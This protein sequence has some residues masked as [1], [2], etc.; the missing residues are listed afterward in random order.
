MQSTKK[1][2]WI[3]LFFGLI[4][5]GCFSFKKS[6]SAEYLA[7]RLVHLLITESL[8]LGKPKEPLR[9]ETI[10]LGKWIRDELITNAGQSF[11]MDHDTD[12]IESSRTQN[13][14]PI[15]RALIQQLQNINNFLFMNRAVPKSE[16]A[17]ERI[18]KAVLS[19]ASI[20][21]IRTIVMMSMK[22]TQS[23][24][25]GLASIDP[26]G[27]HIHFLLVPSETDD[28]LASME[29][30]DDPAEAV[31]TLRDLHAR[32]PFLTI[33]AERTIDFLESDHPEEQKR[34]YYHE[35]L[36]LF[37]FYAAYSY[38]LGQERQFVYI[39]QH[40]LPGYFIGVF[41]IHPSGNP[42]SVED[43]LGS[44]LQK[45][46]VIEPKEDGF[47]VH[48][49]F[50]GHNLNEESRVIRYRNDSWNLTSSADPVH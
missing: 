48:Y 12:S 3:I 2:F 20:Q 19:D 46:L 14:I 23:E 32:L 26:S 47:E 22:E 37:R 7:D 24:L 8:P 31:K 34:H 30:C 36:G 42:P 29:I 15:S 18:Q 43:R 1:L 13:R 5:G 44:F 4:G 17:F 50:Y 27:S 10:T 28:L 11:R 21:S 39:A 25:G 41:H 35:F 40:R 38:L 49:I 6:H 16:I 45:N 33:R 9:Q